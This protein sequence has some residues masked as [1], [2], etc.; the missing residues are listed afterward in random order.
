MYSD[1]KRDINNTTSKHA[2]FNTR[3]VFVALWVLFTTTLILWSHLYLRINSITFDSSYEYFLNLHPWK[4]MMD[5]VLI[6]YSPPLYAVLLKIFSCIFGDGL[7]TLRVF[8][9]VLLS[10]LFFFALFPLRRL[11][12]A[13]CAVVAAVFF[14]TT[15]YNTYF[16]LEIRP[17]ILA[18]VVTTGMMIYAL[19]V[20]FGKE[21]RDLIAFT[22]LASLCMYSH[23]VSLV[24]AFCVY[25]TGVMAAII[26]KKKDVLK[27][28]LIS[29]VTVTVLYIPWLIV[30]ISQFGSAADSYWTLK[31]SLFYGASIALFG[32]VSN[33]WFIVA[34]YIVLMLIF[35]LPLISL[36]LIIDRDRFNK[37]RHINE[38]I[39][40]D[41]IRRKCP[42]LGKLLYMALTLVISITFFWLITQFVLPIFTER[43]F[44]IF[45][46]GAIIVLAGLC[47]FVKD[48][49]AP[50]VMMSAV[51]IFTCICNTAALKRVISA[52]NE[53]I[54]NQK[55]MELS[56]GDPV[57]IHFHEHGLELMGYNFPDSKHFISCDMYTVMNTLDVFGVDTE[58][59]DSNDD[60]WDY[61]DEVYVFCEY[62]LMF[63]KDPNPITYYE[64]FFEDREGLTVEI[65]DY[66]VPSY[67]IAY[68]TDYNYVLRITKN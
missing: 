6:D 36:V 37:A 38:L 34:D 30:F 47:T 54:V 31:R 2:G 49:K 21:K 16:G 18:Y 55:I 63:Q 20:F 44:Y 43:Y 9:T 39:T 41:E 59:L 52:G 8:S 1:S 3:R 12:G 13:K 66:Y 50:A 67:C 53:D 26:M 57:F 23:Y 35:F 64:S 7:V 45:S 28:Y 58:Y 14:L 5:L 46:G 48:K 10:L 32:A 40:R 4:E 68:M 51:M 19:L 15:N 24:T 56:G 62:N 42:D 17:T 60:I 29:G 27:N 25:G 33:N 11:M 65:V 22:V 61:T